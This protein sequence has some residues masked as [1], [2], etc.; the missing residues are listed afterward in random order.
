MFSNELTWLCQ[1][2]RPLI[3]WQAASLLSSAVGVIFAVLTPLILKWL[4][5]TV[6]PLGR[7]ELL[8]L[9]VLLIL[10]TYLGRILFASV[11]GY[12][13]VCAAQRMALR[14]R[15]EVLQHLDSLSTEYH[16]R[17]PAGTSLYALREP[18]DEIT[19]FGTDFFPSLFR[20]LFSS[21]LALF[22][23]ATLN[24]DLAISV[25]PVVPLFLLVRYRFRRR[26]EQEAEILQAQRADLSA[27]LDEHFASLAQVQILRQVKR[28]EASAFR[29]LARAVRSQIHLARSGVSFTVSTNLAAALAMSTVIGYGGWSV[30][31]G[32]L[33]AGG[34]IAFYTYL[35]QLFDP[36]GAAMEMYART[37]KTFAS[38]RY[39]RDVL[40]VAPAVK[41]A[42]WAVALPKEARCELT[43][44]NVRFGY[45]NRKSVIHV[46]SLV[47][48][49]GERL[50]V[51][52]E[53]GAGK[54]TLVKLAARLYDPDSGNIKLGGFDLREL[55]IDALRSELAYLPQYPILFNDTLARN[56]KLGRRAA[57]RDELAEVLDAVDLLRFVEALPRG[58][59]ESV[60]P[61][62]CQL[63]GGQRQR[64]ALARALLQRPRL[65]VLDEA[66][67]CLEPAAELQIFRRI[68]R[69]LPGS[70][71]ILVSH[72]PSNFPYFDRIAVMK[73]GTVAA[74]GSPS[75]LR[76]ADRAYAALFN[77]ARETPAENV[78]S[79]PPL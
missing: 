58:W 54:S 64:L 67:S 4:I 62:G 38:I 43:F 5:D 30:L 19:Y 13:T 39:V 44:Q 69:A 14:L 75:L 40:A 36:L 6:L 35:V 47:I 49:A 20:A 63:S 15:M 59:D 42:P 41:N 45:P 7:S 65:L 17:V 55:R 70:T 79:H 23:M 21:A 56:V 77:T 22:V 26:L 12:L 11:A 27:F 73:D 60:G 24:R 46:S 8:P 28:R 68:T 50:V 78:S 25:L 2:I 29:F 32:R 9:V 34:L 52:G 48:P 37:Q 66:T 61:S 51:A 33:T 53:N 3:V 10:L 1:K 72:R 31:H 76:T 71:F 16:D 74:D 18:I 57:T